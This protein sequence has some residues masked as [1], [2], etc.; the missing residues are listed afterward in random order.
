MSK[1]VKYEV[2]L[3][4][5]ELAFFDR[6][7]C[8][9]EQ[10]KNNN[11]ILGGKKLRNELKDFNKDD[12]DKTVQVNIKS[13]GIY[14]QTDR[15]ALGN[16]NREYTFLIRIPFWGGGD[17]KSSTY[18]KISKLA[19]K[20]SSDEFGKPSLRLTSRQGIQLH[21]V[22]KKNIFPIVKE[23]V[24]IDLLT[25]N[26]CGDNTRNPIASP[27]KSN[28]FN[29]TALAEKIG[30]YFRLPVNEHLQV[31]G[32]KSNIHDTEKKYNYTKTGLP[33]KFK[34]GIAGAYIN[35]ATGKI[36][37]DNSPDIQTND[38]GIAPIVK[39]KK[40]TGYQI[41][42]GGGLGEK[43]G[44]ITFALLGIPLGVVYSE[45]EIIPLI[46]AIIDEWNILGDR[47]NRHWARLKNVILKKGQQLENLSTEEILKSEKKRRIAQSKGVEW[48]RERLEKKG[49]KIE[50][51]IKLSLGKKHRHHGWLKQY[52]SKFTFGLWIENGRIS[53]T[54]ENIKTMIDEIAEH[55]KPNIRLTPFQ[56]LLFTD[57]SDENKPELENILQKYQYSFPSELRR[58]SM[59]C[60]GLPTCS[61][62]VADSERYF[63]PL[64]NILE[65]E[66]VH[67][68]E[69]I[70]VGL[71]GC[72]RHCSRNICHPISIE[73]KGSGC[74]QLKL[75]FGKHG[76]EILAKDIIHK[77][78]KH[79]RIIPDKDIPSLIQLLVD[80][81][82]KNKLP[83]ENEIG[84]FHQRIGVSG[85]ISLIEN[86]KSLDHLLEKTYDEY[87]T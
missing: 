27:I 68:V 82:K 59:S 78:K 58:N 32:I 26:G 49:I 2:S 77:N 67:K 66:E 25:L 8:K 60:V 86:N 71:S 31:F 70:S 36:V 48:L 23:L 14:L 83:E 74:Y 75:L 54:K 16:G 56:D 47:K 20:Y 6:D 19:E 52:D 39:Y 29:A 22:A 50:P 63:R 21:R 80:N 5:L 40:I 51:P 85:I 44:K 18:L 87:F 64:M 13:H 72:E 24:E 62:A 3:N 38:L 7:I 73:G 10:N 55:I 12:V 4:E 46:E 42:I 79:L 1:I 81:Y 69:N 41:Y 9:D 76:T 43:N 35:Q 34:I 45:D 65:D 33:R 84:V 57:I 30:A 61:F 37:K 17:I 11:G 53:D 15:N 28:I